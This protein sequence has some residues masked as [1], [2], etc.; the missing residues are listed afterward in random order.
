[1]ADSALIAKKVHHHWAEIRP[2]Y[3]DLMDAGS[4]RLGYI[5]EKLISLSVLTKQISSTLEGIKRHI[6][7]F[8]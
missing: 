6:I 1:M 5:Y 8:N 2:S 7:G 4:F 3:V